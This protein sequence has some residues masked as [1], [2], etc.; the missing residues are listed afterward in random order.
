MR[1]VTS[2][3]TRK[4]L[5]KILPY[6]LLIGVVALVM[7]PILAVVSGWLQVDADLW[8]HLISTRLPQLLLNTLYLVCIVSIGVLI[9]G[10]GLA[11]LI[12][13]YDFAGRAVI[14]W[15]LMLPMAIPAYVMA[16]VYLGVFEYSG[17]LQTYFRDSGLDFLTIRDVRNPLSIGVVMV[18][19]LYPYVYLLARNAFLSQGKQFAEAA[20]SLGA[21]KWRVAMTVNV[22]MA[23]P[24][25]IAGLALVMMETLADFGTVA[26]FNYDTFT[27]AIY[28]AWFDYFDLRLA[29]QLASLLL[30]LVSVALIIESNA[31][32][33]RGYN[34]KLSCHQ[35]KKLM[36][37]KALAAFVVSA[38]VI[39]F[40]FV[41]P[42]LQ[43]IAWALNDVSTLFQPAFQHLVWRTI[44]LASMAA[45]VTV[46]VAMLLSFIQRH[47]NAA[48][49]ARLMV[50]AKLGYALP[51]TVLAVGIVMP[52]GHLEQ[53]WA[54]LLA[55]MGLAPQ[56][57]L[58]GTV[59][60][61]I[62]AYAVRFLTVAMGPIETSLA[63]LSRS[64]PEAAK[65][66][67]A[68]RWRIVS[69][70]YFPLLRPGILLAILMVFVDVMKEMPATL[71]MRPFGWDTL[72]VRIYEMTSEGEYERAAL[73]ALCLLLVGL[74]PIIYTIKRGQR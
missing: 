65:T 4:A 30:V 5:I 60:A 8:Q 51:G 55:N 40:C 50:M 1:Q 68:T 52:L 18:S 56:Q 27:L 28:K 9:V 42:V 7:V 34:D 39:V 19:V 33:K 44:T 53:W 11:W 43:L 37:L 49:I 63:R 22:G 36:G 14:E 6:S 32:G 46:I 35:R 17:P 13:Q 48:W 41:L 26:I 24:A 25:I 61:L 16:F 57:L 59:T 29:C 72:A 15:A 23:R 47:H 12:S 74:L 64:I 54:P 45:F 20:Q 21:S 73:P 71:L 70:V 31:R 10:V 58:L 62:I 67:G 69:T 3:L 2:K 38:L 66:L